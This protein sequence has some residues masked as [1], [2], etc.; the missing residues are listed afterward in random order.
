MKQWI[1]D[2]WKLLVE[3]LIGLV[4][5]I[6]GGLA[7]LFFL[8]SGKINTKNEDAKIAELNKEKAKDEKIINDSHYND[9]NNDGTIK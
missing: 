4:T 1:K 3:A 2:H 9:Y 5:F 8:N 6:A 7:A